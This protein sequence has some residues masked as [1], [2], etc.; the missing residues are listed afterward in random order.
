M[1]FRNVPAAKAVWLMTLGRHYLQHKS[2]AAL[3]RFLRCC[4][5]FP[6]IRCRGA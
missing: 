2:R 3:T 6:D 1:M 4:Y 5:A